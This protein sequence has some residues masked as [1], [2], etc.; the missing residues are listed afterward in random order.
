MALFDGAQLFKGPCLRFWAR[1]VLIIWATH[2]NRVCC[3]CNVG[4]KP[5]GVNAPEVR[6]THQFGLEEGR[7]NAGVKSTP[8]IGD[9]QKSMELQD[10]SWDVDEG[11]D[12]PHDAGAPSPELVLGIR[13]PA[14]C[15]I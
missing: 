8:A 1:V 15:D 13:L 4:C 12:V 7:R 10:S 9:G 11:R 5:A 6:M 3:C 14:L 2:G